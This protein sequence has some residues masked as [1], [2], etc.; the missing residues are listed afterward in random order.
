M[1]LP[2]SLIYSSAFLSQRG[3]SVAPSTTW[4]TIIRVAS[5]GDAL[6]IGG[7]EQFIKGQ[8]LGGQVAAVDLHQAKVDA[9]AL[10]DELCCEAGRLALRLGSG[11]FSQVVVVLRRICLKGILT[12]ASIYK[13]FRTYNR[14][15]GFQRNPL[16]SCVV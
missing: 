5:G 4:C 10:G 12:S 16:S 11:A 1:L 15:K 3:P 7:V 13:Q 2:A 9:M 14:N 6:A 8:P